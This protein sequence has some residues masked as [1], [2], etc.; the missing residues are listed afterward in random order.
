MKQEPTLY[1]FSMA[2][3]RAVNLFY[4]IIL[5]LMILIIFGEELN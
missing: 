4:L 5:D 2:S 3:M 1:E